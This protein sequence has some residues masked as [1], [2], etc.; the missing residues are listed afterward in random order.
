MFNCLIAC[1]VFVCVWGGGGGGIARNYNLNICPAV[2]AC[3]IYE[4]I[5]AQYMKLFLPSDP[6]PFPSPSLP[7]YSPILLSIIPL[8]PLS[9]PSLSHSPPPSSHPVS[10]GSRCCEMVLVG[11]EEGA[12]STCL[13]CDIK[14]SDNPVLLPIEGHVEVCV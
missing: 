1:V 10:G 3:S 5:F 8:Q 6:L 12:F 11:R 9:F 14:N 7:S 4:V 2:I 13:Q